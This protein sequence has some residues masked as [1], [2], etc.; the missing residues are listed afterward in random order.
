M[1][2]HYSTPAPTPPPELYRSLESSSFA[3]I[4]DG[5]STPAG[6]CEPPVDRAA[7]NEMHMI[8]QGGFGK[9]TAA[10]KNRG[11]DKGVVYAIKSL[12]KAAVLRRNHVTMV[13]RERNLLAKLKCPHL[14]NMHVSGPV[15]VL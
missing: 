2:C 11:F 7:F 1:G 6:S 8:G 4:V 13:M 3:P 10:V 9:V 12:D 15:P 5:P 14:V